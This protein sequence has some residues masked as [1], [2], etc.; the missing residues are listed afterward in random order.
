[1]NWTGRVVWKHE[2]LTETA[3]RLGYI[4]MPLIDSVLSGQVGRAWPGAIVLVRIANIVV[5]PEL[6]QRS[7]DRIVTETTFA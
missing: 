5:L 4:A 3:V 1:M 6:M 7:L 2:H